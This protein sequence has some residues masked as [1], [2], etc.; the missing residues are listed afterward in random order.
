MPMTGPAEREIRDFTKPM[1]PHQFRIDDDVFSAPA[2]LSPVV[3]KK[4][5]K[6]IVTLQDIGTGAALMANLDVM[7][8]VVT[9]VFRALMPGASGKRFGDRLNTRG[10]VAGD[11]VNEDEPDGDVVTE[12]DPPPIGLL[13]Q[14]LPALNY[15]LECYGMRPTEPSEPSPSGSTE[16]TTDIQ[17]ELTSSTAGA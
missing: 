2:L 6:D 9:R 15:L 7:M 5:G 3:I 17:S 8:D 13:D 10:R 1:Q 4:L 11:P 12:D 16:A 14:A